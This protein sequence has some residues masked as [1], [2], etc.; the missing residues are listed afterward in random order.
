M[1]A[2]VEALG[3]RRGQP[4]VMWQAGDA[5]PPGPQDAE[6]RIMAPSNLVSTGKGRRMGASECSAR[7]RPE[8]VRP[9]G[10]RIMPA[11][12]DSNASLEEAVR[13]LLAEIGEDP[14]P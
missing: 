11:M 4:I 9:L 2:V 10:R 12:A 3:Q 1:E 13:T 6:W 7:Q 5:Q 14:A 8:Q